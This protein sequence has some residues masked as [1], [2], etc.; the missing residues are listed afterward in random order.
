MANNNNK[1]CFILNVTNMLINN[2]L[3][4]QESF[5]EKDIESY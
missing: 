4:N 1:L 2:D 5:Y 3:E